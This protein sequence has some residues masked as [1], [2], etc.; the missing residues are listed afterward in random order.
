M[1]RYVTQVDPRKVR[2]IDVH[3]HVEQ[4]EHGYVSM[5][6]EL[7]AAAS[8][9]FRGGEIPLPTVDHLAEVYRELDMAA[10]VFTVDAI[11]QTGITPISSAGIARKC[12]EHADVLIPFGS[13]D[14]RAG[15]RAV[16][17]ATEL[18]EEHGVCGF[19]FHPSVQGFSPDHEE[20]GPLWQRIAELG[21]PA[22]F[23]TGQTGIGAGLPGGHGIKL[24]YSNPMLL[25]DV[26]AD[27]PDLTIILAHPSVPWQDE[28][29]SIATHKSN[30]YIDLSGWSPKHFPPSLVA[31]IRGQLRKKVIFGSDY[32]MI[33]PDRWL[34]GFADYEIDERITE[35]ILKNTTA[36]ILGLTKGD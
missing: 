29:I 35:D 17:L 36:K 2:A 16:D 23:H 1:S 31:A 20:F 22:L 10:V 15:A 21:V 5:D 25:D 4:D 11:T 24:R 14:P 7:A 30:V 32:P 6:K 8:A 33:H 19:K 34:A 12:Q 26:A 27:H 18:V 28:A 13:V 9:Y 3:V